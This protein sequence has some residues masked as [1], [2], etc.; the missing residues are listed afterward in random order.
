MGADLIAAENGDV[1]AKN[2][3][4]TAIG[5]KL[6][7]NVQEVQF[8]ST[9]FMDVD[10]PGGNPV[11][12]RFV[13]NRRDLA[14][15]KQTTTWTNATPHGE[16]AR[17]RWASIVPSSSAATINA[18]NGDRSGERPERALEKKVLTDLAER[19]LGHTDGTPASRDAVR[20]IIRRSERA[21]RRPERHQYAH[22][23]RQR[24][25]DS[26]RIG[27]AAHAA[28]STTS[29][30]PDRRTSLTTPAQRTALIGRARDT[31]TSQRAAIYGE[32]DLRRQR[33]SHGRTGRAQDRHEHA[34]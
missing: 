21:Q 12:E 5:D 4:K 29:T 33:D 16:G 34:R 19:G 1:A 28:R 7:Q 10:P 20:A 17:H 9:N 18:V 2:R 26:R 3:L 25:S 32:P 11:R 23:L 22:L 8:K 24:R 15:L 6:R 27:G 14:Y 30:Q 13:Y 31:V